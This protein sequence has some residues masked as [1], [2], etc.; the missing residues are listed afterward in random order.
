MNKF[1]HYKILIILHCR[2]YQRDIKE[3]LYL[4][5][6]IPLFLTSICIKINLGS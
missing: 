6:D 3:Q 5:N 4:F 2:R 1:R